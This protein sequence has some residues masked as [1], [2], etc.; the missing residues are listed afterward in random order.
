MEIGCQVKDRSTVELRFYVRSDDTIFLVDKF[1]EEVIVGVLDVD[2]AQD[3]IACAIG[4][5]LLERTPIGSHVER[6]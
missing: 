5:K 6:R 2:S 4:S 3:K 1:G